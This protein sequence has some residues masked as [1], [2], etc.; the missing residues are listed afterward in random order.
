MNK[1]F[2]TNIISLGLIGFGF[3]S[4]IYS[5]TIKTMGLYS[6]SG[7]ITNWLAIHM[8]FEK[9]PGLYGSGIITERFQEFKGAIRSMIMNQFF[10]KENFEKF[11]SSNSGGLVKIEEETIMKTIDFDKIF[12]KLKQ[13]ILESP[14]GGMLGMFGGEA[15]LEPL[16][17]Q[18]EVKFREIIADIIKDENFISN[19]TQ[20]GEG[21]SSIADSI[22]TM[23]DGRLD[24]LT[25]QMVKEIIQT[26][27]KEHLGWLVVW[28]GVFGA[29]IGL[30]S[31][32]IP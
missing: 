12:N 24:E 13:A 21:S 27:I 32:L 1:S 22:E 8:L 4:P 20:S 15:A 3:I 2:V 25:P 11:M 30:I 14:F 26:M 5:D 9:V 17:P 6:F 18:F 10:T 16:K 29:L 28:G 23:V 31:T 7:A 19:L